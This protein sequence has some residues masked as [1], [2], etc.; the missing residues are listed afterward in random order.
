MIPNLH[1]WAPPH[2][3]QGPFNEENMSETINGHAHPDRSPPAGGIVAV[4]LYRTKGTQPVWARLLANEYAGL[5]T[6]FYRG[7]SYYCCG[8]DCRVPSHAIDCTWRGYTPALILTNKAG[9]LY[10]RPHCLEITEHLELDMRGIFARGQLWEIYRRM[11]K[12]GDREPVEGRLHDDPPPADLPPAF[13]VLPCLRAVHHRTDVE[14]CHPSPMPPRVYL[15][16][17]PAEIPAE[18]KPKPAN[19]GAAS[20]SMAEEFERMQREK[21][22][23]KPSPSSAQSAS[24]GS[25]RAIPHPSN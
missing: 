24:R 23:A 22:R 15:A 2:G 14:L 1:P 25:S 19:D 12:R 16:E 13:D 9:K 20:R 11:G 8:K 7:R 6:H 10:W 18:I 4:E 21:A 5:F 3:A 17:L